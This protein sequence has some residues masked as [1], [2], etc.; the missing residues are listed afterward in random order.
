M[1]QNGFESDEEESYWLKFERQRIESEQAEEDY[2]RQLQE[3]ESD[4]DNLIKDG[5]NG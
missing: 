5:I 2:Y 4:Y 3:D 1:N